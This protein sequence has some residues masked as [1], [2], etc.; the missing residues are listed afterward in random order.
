MVS[1][2]RSYIL[3]KHPR[4]GR[5]RR[6]SLPARGRDEIVF[7]F[8]SYKDYIP[9][10]PA[11]EGRFLEASRKRS[12]N[13]APA[14]AVRSRAPGTAP[15]PRLRPLR[16]GARSSLTERR[17]G[18]SREARPGPGNR[19]DGAPQGERRSLP[20]ARTERW[21]RRAALHP[22][23]R[24]GAGPDRSNS[25]AITRRGNEGACPKYEQKGFLFWP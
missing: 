15:G 25:R 16:A 11:H 6:P 21:L 3:S 1:C 20:P 5:L 12:G 24:F 7:D 19:R 22:P 8:F 18:A 14:R 17:F 13:A 2:R 10:T 9:R 4:P 23:R